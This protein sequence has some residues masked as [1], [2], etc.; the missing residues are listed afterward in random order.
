MG[1]KWLFVI[2]VS[3]AVSGCI[4]VEPKYSDEKI[5][6]KEGFPEIAL[7]LGRVKPDCVLSSEVWEPV[8]IANNITT[9]RRVSNTLQ[10]MVDNGQIMYFQDK[11]VIAVGANYCQK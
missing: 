5:A 2:S 1:K 8:F 9:S 10:G 3:L 6:A 4:T 11:R 7:Q